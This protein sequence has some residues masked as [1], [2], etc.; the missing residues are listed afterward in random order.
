MVDFKH[1]RNQAFYDYWLSLPR[2][3]VLPHRRSFLPEAIPSLL[4]SMVIYELISPEFIKIRLFGSSLQDRYGIN[5]T[6]TNYLD[7]VENHRRSKAS[8]AMWSQAK[9]PCGMH[10]FIEQELNSGRIAYIEALGLPVLSDQSDTPLLLFQ[11][12]EIVK[13]GRDFNGH[14]ED[15]G[16][17]RLTVARRSFLD[18]GA[19]VSNYSD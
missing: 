10:A 3:G 5:R 17:K 15:F 4:S 13:E 19:G 9:K 14:E 11:S 8:Q 2:D 18:L 7:M 1:S 16:F 12:N 6:G